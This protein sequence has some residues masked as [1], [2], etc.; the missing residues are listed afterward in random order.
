MKIPGLIGGIGPESTIEYYRQIIAAYRQQTG[1]GSYPELLVNSI[2]MKKMLDLIGAN[3]LEAVTDYLL[4]EVY[5]LEQA[6]AN[7]GALASNTPH[8]VFEA[9]SARAPIPL[10]SIVE[11][12]CDAAKALEMHRVGLF[13][14]RFTMQGRFYPEVF[15]RKGITLATPAPDEQTY[16]H[17]K[18]MGELV[19]GIIREETRTHLLAIASRMKAEDGIEGLILG[20]TELPLILGNVRI[21]MPLLDTT[22]IHVERIVAEMLAD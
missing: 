2:N 19:N 21:G 11:T 13:G 4:K 5:R 1:D 14:T 9:L 17:D 22:C 10:I 8:L 3:E 7:F 18:Y 16:I 12:A 6:G 20:G 15:Q